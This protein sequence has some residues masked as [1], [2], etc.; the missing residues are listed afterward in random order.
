M[1]LEG[2]RKKFGDFEALRGLTF[3]VEPGEFLTLLGPSG[4]GK[5][6]LLR[7]ISG[8][9][10]PTEGKVFIGQRDVTRLPAHKRDIGFVFQNYALF[11]HMSVFDNIAFPLKVRR[12]PRDEIRRR[13]FAMLDQLE[14]SGLEKRYPGQLSGGQQQRVALARAIA[15][16]PEILLMDEPLGSLDKRLRQQLQI[17]IRRFQRELGITTIYVTHDQDEA[18]SMSDRI[19]VMHEGVVRQMATPI[20]IYRHPADLFVANFVGDLNRLEAE[21][22]E[23]KGSIALVRTADGLAVSVRAE[24]IAPGTTIIVSAVRPERVKVGRKIHADNCYRGRVT[25]LTFQGSH[26]VAE[27]DLSNGRRFLAQLPDEESNLQEGDEV[28]IGWD[29]LDALVFSADGRNRRDAP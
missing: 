2:L 23:V 15:F 3:S 17:E 20:E 26:H 28:W 9:L 6:T 27:V 18:F 10:E 1:R 19:V 11:P 14:L 7:L 8:I 13:I 16:E 29:I 12:Q 21:V 24:S 5:T 22:V 4:S 25:L